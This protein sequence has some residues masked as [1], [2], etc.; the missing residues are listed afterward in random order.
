MCLYSIGKTHNLKYVK[1]KNNSY[2]IVRVDK[3]ESPHIPSLARAQQILNSEGAVF[4]VEKPRDIKAVWKKPENILRKD[5]Q[6]WKALVGEMIIVP[7]TLRHV[8]LLL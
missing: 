5:L 4:V 7:A 2:K 3:S 6:R 8:R 1:L